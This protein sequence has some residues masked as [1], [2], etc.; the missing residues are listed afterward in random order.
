MCH[1]NYVKLFEWV[2]SFAILSPR[3]R[4]Q[5]YSLFCSRI[6]IIHKMVIVERWNN[7]IIYS[8]ENVCVATRIASII[9][10]ENISA[11]ADETRKLSYFGMHR[12]IGR[13]RVEDCRDF[14]ILF[15]AIMMMRRTPSTPHITSTIVCNICRLNRRTYSIGRKRV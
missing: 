13:I 8:W 11:N 9:A 7:Q 12:G 1:N 15:L 3:Q 14:R 4:R 5:C 10:N 2:L 6:I